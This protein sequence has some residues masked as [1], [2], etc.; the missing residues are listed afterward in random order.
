MD[1]DQILLAVV[2]MLTAV[3]IA[4]GVAKKLNLGSIVALLAVGMALGPHSPRPLLTDHIDELQAVGEIGVVLLLFVIGLGTK[5]ERLLSMRRLVFGLGTAQLLLTAAAIAGLLIAVAVE[6]W[7]WAL[8]VGLGLAMSSDAVAV[9]TL[10]ERAEGASPHGRAVMAVLI[11][12]SFMVIPVLAIIPIL[13]AGPAHSV[14]MPTFDKT[15]QV[16]AAVAAVYGLG[17]YALPKMLTWAALKLGVESF[18]LIIVAAVFGAA[19]AMDRVG[20]SMALGSFMI[21]MFLSTSDFAEQI[22]ASV[23]LMKGL[24]LGLFFIAVGM[25]IDLKEVAALG[26][27]FL[28]ALPALLLIKFAVAFVLALVFGLGL[29]SAVLAGLLLMPLDE[30]AYVIFASA[31]GSGL[32]SDRAYTVGLTMISFSFV[33]S[34]VLINLGYKW[35]D[36]LASAPKPDV[37]LK[38][39]S[40]SIENRV[41]VVGYSYVGRSI[42][43]VLELA[44]VPYIAFEIDFER[45]SEAKKWNHNAHY[46]DVTEP[47]MMGTISIARARSVILT[48]SGYEATKRMIG[49][50]REFYPSVPVMT[51]VQYLVQRDELRRMGA[52]QVV[53]L[54]PEATLRF[55]RSVLSNL[56]VAPD[57]VES[58][59]NAFAA[60]DYAVMRVVGGVGPQT[61]PKEAG[62]VNH[63]EARATPAV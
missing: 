61:T 63:Q 32:L 51:A 9:S 55:S 4:G 45:L 60:D 30:I 47:M 42:C 14:P 50:L 59:I 2:V 41:V 57:E 26:G 17:R 28:L 27:Q 15:L 13:A 16:I 62:V 20:V 29:R 8:I 39:L 21:G 38:A 37:P 40:E 19:W 53:A 44:K 43:A 35:S 7:Q 48:T 31:H 1:T 49:N 54:M 46:G 36:R 6:Q 10:E 56:G 12:Q 3:V 23:S 24:L 18:T 22:K 25:A 5:P 34:P 33:L 52:R 11:N 58:I